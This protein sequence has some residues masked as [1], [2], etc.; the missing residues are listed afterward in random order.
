[1]V[2]LFSV[3][4]IQQIYHKCLYLPCFMIMHRKDV[5]IVWQL[6]MNCMQWNVTSAVYVVISTL[7]PATA[8]ICILLPMSCN[9]AIVILASPFII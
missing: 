9:N 8:C 1:M 6:E 5:D 7:T 3:V 2:I 4:F